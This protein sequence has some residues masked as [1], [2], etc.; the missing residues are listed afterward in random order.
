MPNDVSRE[1]DDWNVS[2]PFLKT[3]VRPNGLRDLDSYLSSNMGLL[4][5]ILGGGGGGGG[6]RAPTQAA[7]AE[8]AP[9]V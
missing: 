6:Q 2:S 3:L 1:T 4:K 7:A 5:R 8:P 9:E